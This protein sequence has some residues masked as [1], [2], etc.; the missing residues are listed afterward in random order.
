MKVKRLKA[1]LA[2]VLAVTLCFSTN[3]ITASAAKKVT[4]KSVKVV[5]PA[6][7]KKVVYVAKGKSVKLTTTVKVTPNTKSNKKVTYKSADT[8]I[9]TVSKNGV[10]KGKKLGTTKITI[11]SA[12]NTKKKKTIK[13][14]VVNPISK[15]TLN[16][17]KATLA[18]GQTTTLKAT[19]KASKKNVFKTLKWTSSNN[20]VAIVTKKG[21]VK[22]VGEG[23]AKIT[24][25]SLDGTKKKVSCTVTVANGIKNIDFNASYDY[26]ASEGIKV[27]LYSP[28]T[29]TKDDFKIKIKWFTD[30]I[31]NQ[32]L[33]VSEIF[34]ADN[35][36][37][38][39]FFYG[40]EIYAGESAQVT[41]KALKGRKTFEKRFI[42]YAEDKEQCI[43]A[44]VGEEINKYVS[45]N[46]SGVGYVSKK[47]VSGSLPKGLTFDS[48]NSNVEGVAKAVANNQKV[49][50]VQTDELGRKSK[51]NVNFLIGDK[52]KIVVQNKAVGNNKDDLIYE[53][54]SIYENLIVKG[55]SG[56]YKFTLLNDYD[57]L[58]R[59]YKEEGT[60]VSIRASSGDIQ[61]AGTYMIKVK[62]T[63]V[64]N[65]SLSATGTLTVKVQDTQKVKV[66]LNKFEE[67]DYGAFGSIYL[68]DYELGRDFSYTTSKYDKDNSQYVYEFNVPKGNYQVYYL[69]YGKEVVMGKNV[70][71][72]GT[73]SISYNM[74]D[75]ADINVTVKDKNGDKYTGSCR[76]RLYDANNPDSYIYSIQTSKGMYKL[77]NVI[78]GKYIVEVYTDSEKVRTGVINISKTDVSADLQFTSLEN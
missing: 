7:S 75:R 12:K 32:E 56:Q 20:K 63:D 19:V 46:Y 71:I 55:G 33:I 48:I 69:R 35:I 67:S 77:E 39:V 73:T 29:L 37:Y 68:I 24:A 57:G 25:S 10:I 5:S 61:N 34:T 9:A 23:T 6:G 4:V 49:T 3:L 22:G 43:S 72:T 53:Y 27:T 54:D 70:K 40:Y 17:K 50:F 52:N 51:V 76:V 78:S 16:N 38:Y 36:N 14:K 60:E 1:L 8:S 74:P 15:V 64:E 11:T 47:I 26:Y 28:Q 30:G 42:P 21:V 2:V 18:I 65:E 45:D 13:V 31:Y 58:F 41:I 62:V 66:T 59:L 44:E